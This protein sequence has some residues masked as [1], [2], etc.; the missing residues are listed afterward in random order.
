MLQDRERSNWVRLRT[1]LILR[2]FAV[3]GQAGAIFVAIMVYDL[4]IEVTAALVTILASVWAN[5]L[6]RIIYPSNK[7][8]S[9]REASL[10]LSFDIVQLGVLLFLTGGLSNPFAL[11]VLAPVT[12]AA[13]VLHLS[14]TVILGAI[15]LAIIT[16][17]WWFNI[18][19]E[20]MSGD[21]L[22][23]PALFQFGFWAALVI[24]VVFLG[25]Y[26]R[27]VTT[28]IHSMGEALLA[29]QMALAR[30]QKLTD[31]GGV[32]AAAAHELGTPLATIKLVSSEL[33]DELETQPD[34]RD[35][36][37]LIRQQADRCRDILKSMGRTGK[38]DLLLRSA[39]LE[40]VVAEAAEPHRERG[41]SVTIDMQDGDQPVIFR[42]PEVVH[43][44]RNLIQNAVDFSK[45][46]VV[47]A[48]SWTSQAITVRICDD[49]Q[50]FPQSVISRIGDP[51]V[52]RRRSGLD[53]RKRPGY[54]GMG[55]GLFIAK[56]LLE[57]SGATLLF[58]NSRRRGIALGGAVVEVTW[59]RQAIDHDLFSDGGLG[60]N[61]QILS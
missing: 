6:F 24:G 55:L 52:R 36:A 37:A 15:A 44:L 39:P 28:E 40:A 12:I 14:S 10:M 49:G 16:L 34:L 48:V 56:T 30:E 54:A 1:L 29:T 33:M 45:E 11:L 58:A 32:V 25:I 7:R 61:Q 2:W 19:L 26:A 8:L 18:P 41:K 4:R 43:G 47:I 53:G 17:L 27:Q 9:E 42:P 31:L 5:V 35:D 21:F 59:P 46:E 38:D 23:L 60:E 20:T 57:R 3:A 13:T 51:F 22:V 50:G